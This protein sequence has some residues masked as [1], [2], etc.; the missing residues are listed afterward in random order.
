VVCHKNVSFSIF[1]YALHHLELAI[2]KFYKKNISS[3]D[4]Y[5]YRQ[6]Q[7]QIYCYIVS[8]D[9]WKKANLLL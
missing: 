8:C 7:S 9:H 3:N 4:S 2:M 5:N 1:V 6:T